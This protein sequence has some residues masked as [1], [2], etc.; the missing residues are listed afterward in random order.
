MMNKNV[1]NELGKLIN[2]C[3]ANLK[4]TEFAVDYYK[5]R[6]VSNELA[7]AFDLGFFPGN[8]NT[9]KKYVDI[10][11][12]VS[13]GI[14]KYSGGSDFSDYY[15]IVIPIK[16]ECG[17]PVAIAGRLTMT[18]EEREYLKLPKYKNSIYKKSNYLYGLDLALE[19]IIEQEEVFVVEG[20]FDQ[21]SMY[22]AGVKNTVALGGTAFSRNH[23]LKLMR[24]CNKICFVLDN[25]EAGIN[26]ARSIQNK[27]SR[28]GINMNFSIC[29]KEFK[30]VDE[31]IRTQNL[32]STALKN[33]LYNNIL[34]M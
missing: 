18:K 19:S 34:I 6:D 29:S 21:I 27:Y 8:L 17:T 2:I 28:Y 12:L 33:K 22:N 13:C 25:D 14:I 32:S 3:K 24:F 5:D 16:N 26:S 15:R 20:Y 10:D 11:S 30:D 23:L 7:D 4:N 1:E 31:M 9:L